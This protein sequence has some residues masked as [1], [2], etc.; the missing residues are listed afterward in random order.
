MDDLAIKEN[1]AAATKH[2]ASLAIDTSGGAFRHVAAELDYPPSISS[3]TGCDERERRTVKRL[4]EWLNIYGFATPIDSDLGPSTSDQLKAF[5][6][7]SNRQPTGRLDQETW[8]LLTAPMRR[9]LA[10]IDHG[11]ASSLEDAVIRVARQ[12]INEMPIEVGGNNRGP[13]VRLYMNG[14]DGA[15]QKWCAGFVCF[16]VAQAAR[17]LNI[18]VPIKREVGVDALVRDAKASG[19]FVAEDDVGD[20]IARRSKLHPG[21]IFVV[22]ASDRRWSHTG[23]IL[24]LNDQTFDTLEGNT[25]GDGG[26]DGP[27]ARQGNRSYT[28]KDFLRLI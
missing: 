11:E 25:G 13:W 17:D 4:Q 9:A 20:A 27:N 26:T 6:T 5:Q 28:K 24:T 7:H 21:S 8:A 16:I 10:N 18:D 3:V 22:R 15:S 19:R 2:V 12:H 1:P 23:F 14:D